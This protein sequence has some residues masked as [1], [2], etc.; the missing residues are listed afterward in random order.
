M[1]EGQPQVEEYQKRDEA[2]RLQEEGAVLLRWKFGRILLA[3]RKAHGT[4]RQLPNGRLAEVC[5]AINRKPREVQYRMKFAEQYE[6]EDEVRNLLRTFD[7]DEDRVP[8]T[9]VIA[10]LTEKPKPVEFEPDK[11]KDEDPWAET[12]EGP[13]A[14]PWLTYLEDTL[15]N[16]PKITPLPTDISDETRDRARWVVNALRGR[17]SWI[18][19]RI[20]DAFA[21]KTEEGQL[22]MDEAA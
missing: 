4:G 3:E 13:S 10:A 15:H 16:C 20:A 11:E 9:L 22:S 1:S 7:P 18:D 8:W 6:T 12:E 17:A 5:A 19:S 2:I 21:A 14:P